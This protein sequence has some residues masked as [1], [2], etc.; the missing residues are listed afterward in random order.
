VAL[1]HVAVG[2]NIA[3]ETHVP[4][5]LTRLHA[6][7]GI[8]AASLFYVTSPIGRP[9]QPDFWNGVIVV[10]AGAA[11]H[12]DVRAALRAIESMEGRVRRGDKWAAR[13]LDLDLLSWH[14]EPVGDARID[15]RERAFL[16]WC[17]ADLDGAHDPRAGPAAPY[18]WSG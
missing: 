6:R 3:P 4:S 13:E 8:V 15:I 9:D 14:N 12:A 10:D 11:S 1:V 16:R 18:R 5:G 7:F 17:L 2:S